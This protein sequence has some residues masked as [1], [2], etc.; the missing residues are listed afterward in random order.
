MITHGAIVLPVVIRGIMEASAIRR[1]FDFVNLESGSAERVF[2]EMPLHWQPARLPLL[3][4]CWFWPDYCLT[5][6]VT[7]F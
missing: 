3:R 7:L 6:R 1:F 5:P 2:G 4:V